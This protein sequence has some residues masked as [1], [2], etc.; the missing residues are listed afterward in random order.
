MH[1]MVEPG[2]VGTFLALHRSRT[3]VASSALLLLGAGAVLIYAL[4]RF[5]AL[6]SVDSTAALLAPY[7]FL[8]YIVWRFRLSP[9]LGTGSDAL[10]VRNEFIEHR[11]PWSEVSDIAWGRDV[12]GQVLRVRA[13]GTTVRSDAYK[14]LVVPGTER[15]RILAFLAEPRRKPATVQGTHRTR[16]V[17]GPAEV[18]C[19]GGFLSCLIAAVN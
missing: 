7:L 12:A 6:T 15:R 4:L 8:Y 18:L 5:D 19:L 11:I 9:G 13:N 16:T 17:F 3:R 14:G 10:V 1:E 2:R